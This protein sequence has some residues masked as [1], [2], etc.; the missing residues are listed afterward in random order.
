MNV[1]PPIEASSTEAV[2]SVS[3]N[4]DAS[5]FSVGLGSGICIFHTKSCLLKASR[6]FNAGIGLVQMM[7]TTNYLALVGGGRSPKFAM[8]KAII[9]DDMKGKVALEITALTA[10]RGVQL[11]RE[12]I[13]VVLQNSVR[14]YSFA[15]PPDL[16]HVYETADNLLGLCC[17]SEKKLAF[18]GRTAGQIQLIELATGN[19]SIIPAH[20][21]ALKAI[22]LSPDG[23]LL[24]SA[25]ET[26]T[27][28]RVYATSNCARLAELRRGIDP[29]T[30]F[31]LA[32]S[33]C[34]TMLACT[35]DKST[36][37]IFDVPHPRKPGM[38]RSQQLGASGSDPGDGT[39]KWGILSKIPLM[40]RVFSDVY[41][42]SSAPFEAGDEAAIGG[43]SFS[44][45]TVLGTSRPPKGVIGWIGD[46]SLVVIGAGHD[47]RWEKF[48]IVD[49]EDGKRHCVREGW[50]RYLGNT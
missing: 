22:A 7:G 50:K 9:W 31:S 21:S 47:A 15:K 13:A 41:S 35:S 44:E 12:R 3:F 43:I 16:L 48:I 40:P 19:V 28:I 5:C 45:S 10:I 24:A 26:G 17:L 29:A 8:N 38:T 34:G 25:S 6:D 20:S 49:G 37:H 36:L 42:F 30:I 32:F 39:G 11:G 33:P 46:D 14:V 23:E 18:P 4:N 27:L 2:L 1:R